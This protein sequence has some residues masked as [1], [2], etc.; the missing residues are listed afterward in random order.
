MNVYRKVMG[1]L[2]FAVIFIIGYNQHLSLKAD[3]S[4]STSEVTD[5][6]QSS[7]DSLTSE[8]R[9]TNI[10][11]QWEALGLKPIEDVHQSSQPNM[12]D[13]G[14]NHLLSIDDSF[15]Y[16]SEVIEFVDDSV[17]ISFDVAESGLYHIALDYYSITDNIMPITFSLKVND[18]YQYNESKQ[19]ILETFWEDEEIGDSLDRYGNEILPQQSQLHKWDKATLRD[20]SRVIKNP[21]LFHLSEGHNTITLSIEQGSMLLGDV[22]LES[23]AEIDD[24]ETYLSKYEDSELIN[25]LTMYEA[26]NMHFKNSPSVKAGIS[27]D[28]GVTPKT[29]NK[30]KVNILD[31]ETYNMSGDAVHYLVDVEEDGFYNLTFKVKQDIYSNSPSFRRIKINDEVPFKEAEKIAFPY[32]TRWEN[33]TLEYKF[34]LEEGENT[35]AL[36]TNASPYHEI[37]ESLQDIITEITFLSLDIKQ[38]TGN[39]A[40]RN[41][42]WDV[43]RFIPGIE[44]QLNTWRQL[45][46]T[47][48]KELESINQTSKASR[49]IVFLN[50]AIDKLDR[51]LEDIDRIPY[52][53]NILSEGSGSVAQLLGDAMGIMLEQPL[54]IDAFYLHGDVD[55]PKS[56]PNFFVKLWVSV[57]RFFLS[58]IN[59]PYDEEVE[60]DEINIW[61]NRNR[62]IVDIMQEM[63]DSQ[64]T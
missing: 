62:Q 40:D 20:A 26:E 29:L 27:R 24:Y 5:E 28:I 36:E 60:P 1:L 64:F 57:Q 31:G 34:Y 48:I 61:V 22:Y 2:I 38:L 32:S 46:N 50:S 53:L 6:A 16:G 11:N 13:R 59:N 14:S 3:I 12:F 37:Y 10:L 8:K 33:V 47:H 45:I 55:L 30:M 44:E 25:T 4:I 41:R 63:A 49:D 21:L 54:S 58:F 9:Y 17:T 42:D 18:E 19:M 35:I 43:E 7:F 23:P 52:R 15:D 56:E 39:N 51:L